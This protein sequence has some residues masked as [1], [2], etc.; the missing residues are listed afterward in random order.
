M[1]DPLPLQTHHLF[2]EPNF[3]HL[4]TVMADGSP[5]SSVVWVTRVGDV[6]ELN[7][8]AGRVKHRNILRNPR[9]SL[10]V[11]NRNR[12]T[13]YVEVRGPAT[14]VTEGADA[15]IVALAHKY[16]GPDVSPSRFEGQPRVIIRIT[17]EHVFYRE[18]TD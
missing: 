17:P 18:P 2:D 10:S 14:L 5:Q 4:A 7:T 12:P 6:V 11:H 3:G 9:V 8:S 15:H 1:A 16:D 13:E